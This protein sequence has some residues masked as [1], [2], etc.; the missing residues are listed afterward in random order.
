M[1]WINTENVFVASIIVT[2]IIIFYIYYIQSYHIIESQ[3]DS[4][5]YAVLTLDNSQD[6]ANI[7]SKVNI[8]MVT[9]ISHL[10][11]KYGKHNKLVDNLLSRYDPDVIY[12]SVPTWLNGGVA[13]TA[14]K[15]KS[16][17]ICLRNTNN[18]E[19]HDLN[20]IMFVALHELSH[21]ATDAKHHP[22]E[23]WRT[24]KFILNESVSIG[25]YRPIDYSKAA[26]SY[27]N[28]MKI[29]YNPLFDPTV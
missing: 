13:Y 14:G 8:N 6:A 5:E 7:L 27:C 26:T 21:I 10:E 24:F 3:L 16:L 18:L 4:K 29:T 11:A 15:G 25:I 9:L 17:Y 2:I 22:A 23:F 19:F 20:T 12:E 1:P 28:D